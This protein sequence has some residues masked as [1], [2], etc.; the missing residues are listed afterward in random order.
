MTRQ[1]QIIK[2]IEALQAKLEKEMAEA[3]PEIFS[4]LSDEVID[5]VGE[6]SLDPDDRAKSLREMILLKRRIGD[7]LVSN[8]VYQTSVKSLTDGFK[9]LANLTD[10][11]MGE[12]LITI[13]ESRICTRQS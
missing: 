4:Q 11:Y 3:L 5:L 1:E 9:E 7:A 10:D 8:V 12:V 2:K 6:L 13:P